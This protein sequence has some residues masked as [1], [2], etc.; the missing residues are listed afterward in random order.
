MLRQ[1][2][3]IL[4][5]DRFTKALSTYFS[6]YAFANSELTDFMDHLN[7]QFLVQEVGHLPFTLQEWQQEWI[8]TAGMNWLC[9]EYVPKNDQ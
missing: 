1:L 6:Q 9:G 3:F 2:L 7:T 8:Q 5:E 4:G